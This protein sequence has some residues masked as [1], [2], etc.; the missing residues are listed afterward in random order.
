MDDKLLHDYVIAYKKY[1]N[2]NP[3]EYKNAR[4]ERWDRI[5]WYQSWDRSKLLAIIPGKRIDVVWETSIGNM[6]R[7]ALETHTSLITAFGSINRL[8]LV[9]DLF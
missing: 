8:Q 9:P 5:S 4:V 1:I 7:E 6:G 3:K 2:A